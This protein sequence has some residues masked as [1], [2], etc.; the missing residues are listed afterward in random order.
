MTSTL[1]LVFSALDRTA[2]RMAAAWAE[3]LFFTPLRDRPS[4]RVRQLLAS[5]RRLP[6]ALGDLPIAAWTWGEGPAVV[7][8]HGWSSRGGHLGAFIPPLVAAGYKAVAFDAPA[9]GDTPGRTTTI[10]EMAGALRAVALAAGG[11]QALVAHSIGGP[12]T[13]FALMQGLVVQRAVFLAPSSSPALYTQR[14]A[15]SLRMKP[16]RVRMLKERAER[17]VGLRF[18]ELDV[19]AVAPRMTVPL[20]VIHDRD[21]VEVPWTQGAAIAEAWPGARLVS[22]RD[23]GHRRLLWHPRVVERAVDFIA[24]RTV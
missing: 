3:R 7:L 5:G 11:A 6:V 24:A 13:T 23:L 20:L 1:Q 14:F 19:T 18:D 12:V 16:E 2:P 21:D 17:R 10:V 22:E 15:E 4:P 9:H 8:V